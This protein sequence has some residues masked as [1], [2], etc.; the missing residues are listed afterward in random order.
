MLWMDNRAEQKELD[1][2]MRRIAAR[3]SG[4]TLS[5]DDNEVGNQRVPRATRQVVVD[6]LSRPA[7]LHDRRPSDPAQG[8]RAGRAGC[9]RG[10]A[11]RADRRFRLAVRVARTGLLAGGQLGGAGNAGC[12]PAD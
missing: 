6:G 7:V 1:R 3:L 8:G 10:R 2:R 5:D 12:E 9:A 4:E 11:G